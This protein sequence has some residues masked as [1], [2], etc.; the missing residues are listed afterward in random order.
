MKLPDVN[1]LVNAVLEESLHHAAAKEWLE[2]SFA[3]PQGLGM[4]WLALVGFI[5]IATRPGLFAQ[6]VP[7]DQAMGL[8]DEWL[9]HPQVRVLHPGPRHAGILGRLLVAAGTGGNLTND[10]H[11]AALAIEHNAEVGTFDR[12]FKR[13]A[14]LR[15]QLLV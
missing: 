7:I 11:L 6:P 3:H 9:S 10:A 2:G 5:R 15:F 8:V 12:D 13:F 1:V 14:G 4:A